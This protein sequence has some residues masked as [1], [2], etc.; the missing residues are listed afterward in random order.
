MAVRRVL[1]Q[2][3]VGSEVAVVTVGDQVEGVTMEVGRITW[4]ILTIEI[5]EGVIFRRTTGNLGVVISGVM[6]N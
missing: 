4:V 3:E 2:R 5:R 1:V 6:G